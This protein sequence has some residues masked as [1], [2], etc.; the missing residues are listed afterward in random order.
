[1]VNSKVNNDL[2]IE[3]LVTRLMEAKSTSDYS[4]VYSDLSSISKSMLL[5]TVLA[6]FKL[7]DG[8]PEENFLITNSFADTN[9]WKAKIMLDNSHGKGTPN[10]GSLQSI[11]Y[12]MI[13]TKDNTIIPIA[14]NDEHRMG[15]EVM[16]DIYREKYKVEVGG[17]FS[18]CVISK[19][20]V[21]EEK[22]IPKFILAG[23]KFLSYGG[24]PNATVY[25]NYGDHRGLECTISDFVSNQGNVET[26][27]KLSM[28]KANS[29]ADKFLE[30]WQNLAN[31][32]KKN[33]SS[34]GLPY[35]VKNVKALIKW[36]KS[37]LPIYTWTD[38][39]E[40]ETAMD[41]V[42]TESDFKTLDTFIFGILPHSN[43]YL[44]EIEDQEFQGLKNWIHN[45]IRKKFASLNW[46][47]AELK[48]TFGSN[49]ELVI[50]GL[51]NIQ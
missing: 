5:E 41:L 36:M 25:I 2:L 22:E 21:F 9:K 30:L 20:Y 10:K 40:I 14:R 33:G 11:G 47:E 42:A 16:H 32:F 48:N 1:M 18:F 28:T 49:T 31:V 3:K 17:Y 45:D 37:N 7:P 24:N 38:F 35:L 39:S 13:S 12:V 26:I 27:S 43:P 46:H 44:A 15:Y 4:K 51:S 23:T 34:H 50:A 6:S 8:V 19:N 29:K